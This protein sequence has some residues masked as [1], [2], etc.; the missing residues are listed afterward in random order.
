MCGTFCDNQQRQ[1]DGLTVS[2]QTNQQKTNKQQQQQQTKADRQVD[3]LTVWLTKAVS[4]HFPE[5]FANP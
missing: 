4:I 2:K 5:S 1:V 3:E